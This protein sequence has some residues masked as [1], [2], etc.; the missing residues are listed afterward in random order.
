VRPLVIIGIFLVCIAGCGAALARPMQD[1]E[2]DNARIIEMTRI[3][4]GD[5][6]IIAKIKTTH[7]NFTLTDNDLVELKR[8]N[9]S[10]KVVAAMLEAS[11]IK[12]ARVKIDGN[13]VEAHTVGQ[14]KAGGRLG[15]TLTF[16]IKSTKSK[17]YLQGQHASVIVSK[18]PVIEIE[19]PPNHS[20]DDYVVVSMDGK[21]D[22]R[23]LEVGSGG[24]VVGFKHGLRAERIARTSYDPLGGRR[25]KMTVQGGLNGGEYIL[26]VVGSA[27]YDKGI[28]GMGYDFTVE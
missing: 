15:S 17:A 19:L 27:D 23:E 13:P 18:N 28:Y 9:V 6:I 1:T 4:L 7:P 26:Y 8:A 22:R 16:G 3:G 24:G 5:E 20:I 10:D 21:A 11:V 25:Y 2:L 14:A 12:N